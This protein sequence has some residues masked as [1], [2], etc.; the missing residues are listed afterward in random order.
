MHTW[1]RPYAHTYIQIHKQAAKKNIQTNRQTTYDSIYVSYHGFTHIH[2]HTDSRT[3][4][5]FYAQ[6]LVY[7][8]TSAAPKTCSASWSPSKSPLSP[9]LLVTVSVTGSLVRDCVYGGWFY[10]TQ[11]LIL[12]WSNT[13]LLLFLLRSLYC[14]L[15]LLGQ[16]G[17]DFMEQTIAILDSAVKSED[18]EEMHAILAAAVQFFYAM[19]MH[20][21]G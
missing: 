11:F 7:W 1:K 15:L 20:K 4:R 13:P 18:R 19:V 3:T 12:L 21:L 8:N 16:V 9:C 5:S 6:C 17:T 14:L 2:A 10:R